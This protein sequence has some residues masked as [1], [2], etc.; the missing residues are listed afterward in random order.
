[1]SPARIVY[2]PMLGSEWVVS[3][4]SACKTIEQIRLSGAW[5]DATSIF[6]ELVADLQ[7]ALD[8]MPLNTTG[9]LS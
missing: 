8:G 1:M 4:D 3:T 2:V 7:A 9:E 6:N 5:Y